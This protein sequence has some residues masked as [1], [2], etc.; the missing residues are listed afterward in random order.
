MIMLI[1]QK[2]HARLIR[3]LPAAFVNSPRSPAWARVA[4]SGLIPLA[5][6]ARAGWAAARPPINLTI[7][8]AC[9][10]SDIRAL[11]RRLSPIADQP[12]HVCGTSGSWT[13]IRVSPGFAGFYGLTSA[14]LRRSHS[15]GIMLV[16]QEQYEVLLINST[17]L[18]SCATF[19][20][21]GFG[22]ERG[23]FLASFLRLKKL[24]PV[25]GFARCK[26]WSSESTASRMM[27]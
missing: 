26:A 23:P 3:P 20:F 27:L 16:S 18:I 14:D 1:Y 7:G 13:Q 10:S 4:Q 19:A 15:H 5:H 11:M 17:T 8:N 9:S 6:A 2:H 24:C 22:C 21:V 25:H 12:Q